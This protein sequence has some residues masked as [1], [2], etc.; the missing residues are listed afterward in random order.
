MLICILRSI[1]TTS[2]IANPKT[3][4]TATILSRLITVRIGT[5]QQWNAVTHVYVLCV[6]MA[7]DTDPHHLPSSF[8]VYYTPDYANFTQNETNALKHILPVDCKNIEGVLSV[9][10]FLIICHTN[11]TIFNCVFF[12]RAWDAKHRTMSVTSSSSVVYFLFSPSSL[13]CL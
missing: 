4:L 8:D 11:A 3:Q 12:Y 13:H 2:A 9:S 5:I 6:A 7:V 1:W 10:C